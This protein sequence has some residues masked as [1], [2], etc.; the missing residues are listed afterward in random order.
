MRKVEIMISKL[1]EKLVEEMGYT[2]EAW[3]NAC[4]CSKSFGRCNDCEKGTSILPSCFGENL[5]QLSCKE[6]PYSKDCEY[7]Q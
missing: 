1:K 2:E 4:Y 7:L 6:C 5:K 3:E